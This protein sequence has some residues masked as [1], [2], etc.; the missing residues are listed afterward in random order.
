MFSLFFFLV[1]VL[2]KGDACAVRAGP[3]F[4]DALSFPSQ[5]QPEEDEEAG[6][7]LHGDEDQGAGG[8]GRA[9]GRHQIVKDDIV[10]FTQRGEKKLCEEIGVT[11][12]L[13][14]FLDV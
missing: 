12:S 4:P 3:G 8:P 7:G 2:S 10:R 14:T 13:S 11:G 6:E 5:V 9:S 1:S